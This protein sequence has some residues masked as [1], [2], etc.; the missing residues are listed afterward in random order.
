M[1]ENHE[2][3]FR[4]GNFLFL[5]TP[6]I[7]VTV[8]LDRAMH[9]R[10]PDTYFSVILRHSIHSKPFRP[11]LSARGFPIVALK[12]AGQ[13]A[14][15]E[16]IIITS[17]ANKRLNLCFQLLKP[18]VLIIYDILQL[19]SC[20]QR[21]LYSNNAGCTFRQLILKRP[22]LRMIIYLHVSNIIGDKMQSCLTPFSTHQILN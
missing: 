13:S 1:R 16:Q 18:V 7:V 20:Q 22:N 15:T 5:D 2:N 17:L 11:S 12:C 8:I 4:S 21:I 6:T 3:R 9:T 19:G 10:C 14:R